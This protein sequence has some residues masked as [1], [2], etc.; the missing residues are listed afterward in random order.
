MLP[1]L[2]LRGIESGH[3]GAQA[4]N[5]IPTEARASIDFRLVPNETPESIK[6]LV[7]R[8]LEAQGYTIMRQPPDT[9]TRLAQTRIVKVDWGSGHPPSS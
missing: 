2:N 5:T 7:E 8:H 9:A 4:S 6:P 3:V 1:R